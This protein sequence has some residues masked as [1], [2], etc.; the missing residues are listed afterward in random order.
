L[1]EEKKTRKNYFFQEQLENEELSQ[2]FE[3]KFSKNLIDEF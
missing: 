2:I 3:P 1:I